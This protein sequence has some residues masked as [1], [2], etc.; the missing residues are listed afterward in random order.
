[1]NSRALAASAGI[2]LVVSAVI[3]VLN[4]MWALGGM[5][6][7]ANEWS[8]RLQASADAARTPD[9]PGASAP[10]E[11]EIFGSL[12]GFV[13]HRLSRMLVWSLAAQGTVGIGLIV[14]AARPRPASGRGLTERPA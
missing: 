9:R 2:V 3:T 14:G 11:A 4:G 6:A 13:G 12:N 8:R 7:F 10:T 1:M 5:D